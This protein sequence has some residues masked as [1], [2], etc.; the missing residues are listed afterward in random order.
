M[1]SLEQFLELQAC[2]ED[3]HIL[4]VK[5]L[6]E[7][8][9]VDYKQIIGKA[10]YLSQTQSSASVCRIQKGIPVLREVA[11]ISL[12]WT[13]VDAHCLLEDPSLS[14]TLLPQI[15]ETYTPWSHTPDRLDMVLHLL[16]T[17]IMVL[18]LEP[19]FELRKPIFRAVKE[20]F[21]RNLRQ[22]SSRKWDNL[23]PFSSRHWENLEQPSSQQWRFDIL[24]SATVSYL[25]GLASNGLRRGYGF[26]KDDAWQSLYQSLLEI[27][28][29]I[30]ADPDPVCQN[31]RQNLLLILVQIAGMQDIEGLLP[32]LTR[33]F[34]GGCNLQ[35]RTVCLFIEAFEPMQAELRLC[36]YKLV[37]DYLGA[38]RIQRPFRCK[39]HGG[40]PS[41]VPFPLDQKILL[42]RLTVKWASAFTAQRTLQS[43]GDYA[44]AEFDMEAL[45][46]E[47]GRRLC[48]IVNKSMLEVTRS[49]KTVEL[50]VVI[51][52]I[53]A[54][55]QASEQFWN[56]LI[57]TS[58]LRMRLPFMIDPQTARAAISGDSKEVKNLYARL[59]DVQLGSNARLWHVYNRILL[60]HR[61]L[62]RVKGR[63]ALSLSMS[64]SS[65]FDQSDKI[66][67][68]PTIGC[69]A[70]H[71]AQV[72]NAYFPHWRQS[73]FTL[74]FS[75]RDD[76]PKFPE[77]FTAFIVNPSC[78]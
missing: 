11:Q 34:S 39:R 29:L 20:Q 75:S 32:K 23:E 3:P 37:E 42:R 12:P 16:A 60:M 24:C 41:M 58:S 49:D 31:I 46:I 19:R 64:A 51:P 74:N 18:R 27:W 45:R 33:L 69:S 50:P 14:Q 5:C 36:C 22:L 62:R 30:E 61:E 47:L 8:G 57:L 63:P 13:A 70:D 4:S 2:I 26:T 38:C 71:V 65:F 25:R 73:F 17:L 67:L 52:R 9:L 7:M 40:L 6:L 10:M 59:I 77:H 21:N 44:S 72:V 78:S 35:E 15:F 66:R 54:P 76:L 55:S 48:D 43:I 1:I 28:T 56:M 53:E 68:S